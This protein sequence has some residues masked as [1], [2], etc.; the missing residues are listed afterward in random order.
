MIF[1]HLL[2]FWMARPLK[3]SPLKFVQLR[4]ESTGKYVTVYW[5]EGDVRV[6]SVSYTHASTFEL[7]RVSGIE[8]QVQLRALKNNLYLSAEGGGGYLCVANRTSASGWETFKTTYLTS[9]RIVLESFICQF[10]AV[11]YSHNFQLVASATSSQLAEIFIIDEIPQHRG[12]NLGSWFVPEKWM[13]SYKSDLW[14][15]SDAVDLY[16]LSISLGPEE[17]SKRLYKHWS[18][19]FT[20]SDFKIM[21]SRGINHVRIPIGKLLALISPIIAS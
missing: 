13:F 2:F 20:E 19:W 6:D 10:V 5:P 12:V 7:H 8:N 18:T 15:D 9:N 16:S 17:A 14:V 11:D 3:S 4:S 21:A 1:L